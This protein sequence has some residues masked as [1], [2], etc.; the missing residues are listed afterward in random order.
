[1]AGA[2]P[3]VQRNTNHLAVFRVVRA[4]RYQ[5]RFGTCFQESKSLVF[6]HLDAVHRHNLGVTP[7]RGGSRATLCAILQHC[8]LCAAGAARSRGVGAKNLLLPRTG[9][10]C[11][12]L[13]W[14]SLLRQ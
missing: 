4:F 2:S 6:I 12:V 9:R 7:D 1:M 8:V 10:L 11:H 13:V 14:C 3:R 5:K